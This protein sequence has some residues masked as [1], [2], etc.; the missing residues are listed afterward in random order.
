[1][2]NCF[3]KELN[4]MLDKSFEEKLKEREAVIRQK[5]AAQ[6]KAEKIEPTE[7]TAP[8]PSTDDSP[9]VVKREMEQ[10]LALLKKMAEVPIPI[11]VREMTEDDYPYLLDQIKAAFAKHSIPSENIWLKLTGAQVWGISLFLPYKGLEMKKVGSTIRKV[12]IEELGAS[13]TCLGYYGKNPKFQAHEWYFMP[14]EMPMDIKKQVDLYGEFDMQRDANVELGMGIPIPNKAKATGRVPVLVLNEEL[15]RK[16]ESGEKTT[17][18]RNLVTYYCD[19]FFDTGKMEKAVKFQLGYSGKDGSNPERMAREIKDIMLVS[20]YGKMAPAMTDGKM[21]TFKDLPRVFPPV[22]YALKLGKRLELDQLPDDKLYF[23]D[24]DPLPNMTKDEIH[25]LV[26][27]V[28]AGQL[29]SK[30]ADGYLVLKAEFYDAIESGE[31]KVEYRDFT[32][33]NLKRT[34]GIKTIRFNR[35][36]V[37]NAPQMRWEVE[38]VVLLDGEGNECDPFKVPDGFCPTAIAIHLGKRID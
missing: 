18:Y 4:A 3:E 25:A 16:I 30:S 27:S 23:W 15:Y 22:A 36:Y 38:N 29:K 12:L 5:W 37:K 2:C 21:S 10:E 20:E 28:K 17:E 35:G 7:P 11:G 31:K 9:S 34:I 26:E 32:A 24:A 13:A 33:Y 14:P 19:L 1:M 8:L 6:S